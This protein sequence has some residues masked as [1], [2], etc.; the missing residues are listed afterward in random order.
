MNGSIA[1]SA[2]LSGLTIQGRIILLGDFKA[3]LPD[4]SDVVFQLLR[5]NFA[6]AYSYNI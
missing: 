3:N 5:G 4:I 2:L 1:Q 6:L